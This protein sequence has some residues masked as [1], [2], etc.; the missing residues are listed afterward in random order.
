MDKVA[1][2]VNP[3]CIAPVAYFLPEILRRES[4]ATR[5]DGHKCRKVHLQ[6]PDLPKS[7]NDKVG[8]PRSKH[9]DSVKKTFERSMG[10]RSELLRN[11]YAG[12]AG[13]K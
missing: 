2:G 10:S 5:Y 7:D 12:R 11:G 8:D 1:L 4:N 3:P 13:A 9:D 6:I